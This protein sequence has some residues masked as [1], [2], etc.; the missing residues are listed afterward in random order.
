MYFSNPTHI[1]KHHLQNLCSK[2]LAILPGADI[3]LHLKALHRVL[4]N[5]RWT[6]P[7]DTMKF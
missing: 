5:L 3:L 1:I 4:V 2:V 7:M 6:R